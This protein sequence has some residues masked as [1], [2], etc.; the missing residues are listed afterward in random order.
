MKNKGG[1]T[2]RSGTCPTGGRKKDE[3]GKS[4]QRGT[5]PASRKRARRGRAVIL[6]YVM[7]ADG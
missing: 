4:R 2:G 3:E 1:K 5:C 6:E 7:K